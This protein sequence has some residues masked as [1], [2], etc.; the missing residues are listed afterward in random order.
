MLNID[1]KHAT[2]IGAG[3]AGLTA[4]GLLAGQGVQVTLVEKT[5]FLGGHAVQLNCKAT[6][7]CVKCGACMAEDRLLRAARHPHIEIHT[8]AQIDTISG[9]GPFQV[10]Y[11]IHSPLVN[12]DRCNG[13]GLCLQKCPV[14]G[15][16]LQGRAPRVG[17]YVAIRRDL[18]RY[19]D[20][21]ACTLCRDACPQG[22]IR[23]SSRAQ[24]GRL[25]TDALL[26]ATGFAPYNPSPKP[27][28]YG[29]FQNVIT[30]LDAERLLRDQPVMVR[31]S[32]GRPAGRIAFVQCVG[33]RDARSGQPGCSK[34]C[35]GSSL[36]MARLIQ[37]RRK[38]VGITF[39]YIDVQT[40][41]KDFP[42]FYGSARE[43][44]EMVRAI[45]GDI[46]RTDTDELE[47]VYFDP[48]TN[49]SK[50]ARF[51]LVVLSVGLLPP[52][53]HGHVSR[54]LDWPLDESGFLPPNGSRGQ[55][56]GIF[57]AGAAT[58]PMTIAESVGSAEKTVYDMIR[59]LSA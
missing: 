27:Y 23:L 56:A 25:K 54:T 9:R 19:F 11:R 35:C 59:Y 6:D 14:P 30:S 17:P 31:P 29:R 1:H 53:D 5:P 26:L 47:V 52:G 21:A 24:P 41:G 32:D 15:A 40:F 10:D 2:V 12:A 18:C 4:A 46:M 13:C 36:R 33:S 57:S 42:C 38:G 8:G 50:E 22:A 37:S 7:A 3:V 43:N 16:I 44:I 51:E 28:G 45:P 48:E 49:R 34:I 58:G 20:N 55:P 39:F